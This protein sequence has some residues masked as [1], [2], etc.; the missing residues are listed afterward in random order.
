MDLV[1]HKPYW[2]GPFSVLRINDSCLERVSKL[3]LLGVWQQNNL[4]W[5]Y[6]VEQT[7]KKSN[8]GL[9]YLRDCRKQSYLQRSVSQYIVPRYAH[10]LNNY[11]SPVWGGLPMKYLAEELQSIQNRYL[12]IIRIPRTSLPTLEDRCK[13]AS[14]RE[15]ERIVNDISHCYINYFS[16]SQIPATSI[17]RFSSNTKVRN[18][19]PY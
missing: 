17:T 4:C 19:K 5:N 13:V 12:D 3:K 14:K 18:A 7:V 16:Q 1:L 10:F 9:Y 2:A 11:T 6:H 8:K 15:W